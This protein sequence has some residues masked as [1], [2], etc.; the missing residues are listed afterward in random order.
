MT[1][2]DVTSG[3]LDDVTITMMLPPDNG[4]TTSR[5]LDDG[6]EDH[7]R[8][9]RVTTDATMITVTLAAGQDMRHRLHRPIS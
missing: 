4:P 6:T 5:L 1:V 8:H 9:I 2:D 3:F 7:I